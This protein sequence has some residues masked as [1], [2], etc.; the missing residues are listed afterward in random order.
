MKDSFS[1]EKTDHR[2]ETLQAQY[3]NVQKTNQL[4]RKQVELSANQ[5]ARNVL[6]FGTITILAIALLLFFN[7][8]RLEAKNNEIN[9]Q[10]VLLEKARLELANA[11]RTLEVRVDQ[12]TQELVDANRE[13]VRKNEEIKQA[14]FK[15]QTIERK[16]VAIELHDN[17]SSLL[18]AV[19]MSMQYINARNLSESEQSVYQ[20]VRQMIKNAYS[21]VRNIS[22]NILPAELEKEG[23]ASTLVALV[24]KL[25]QNSP[26]QFSLAIDGL[27][28]RPPAQIEFNIYSIVLELINNVIKH[29]QAT[30]VTIDL[31]HDDSRIE[32]VVS[33]DGI[34]LGKSAAKRGIGLQNIQ[35]RL[36]SLGGTLRVIRP[37]E[38]GTRI[39]IEVPIE[40]S[41]LNGNVLIG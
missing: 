35:T 17:L 31:H 25:N 34:G 11:N 4:Q 12:R 9:G 2:I 38:L 23:L 18:S 20:N 10:K 3:D 26:L 29:A 5:R 6:F 28:E 27:D 22:H 19:S 37:L 36:D 13:L 24:S 16:R 32:L 1:K 14:L 15:G 39:V 33:D 8:K 21:E 7:N 30:S 40:T 41:H